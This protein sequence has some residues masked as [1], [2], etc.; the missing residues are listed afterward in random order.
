MAAGYQILDEP[1]PG[2]LAQVAVNPM[3]PLLAS[4]LAGSWLALPWFALNSFAMGSPTRKREI[5][6]VL[7]GGAGSILI[8]IGLIWVA[9]ATNMTRGGLG[10]AILVP[11]LWKLGVAYALFV[12][13]RRS[14]ALYEYYGGKVRNP[15][16]LL[17][18]AAVARENVLD[19][20]GSFWVV[21]WS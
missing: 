14:F 12:A 9:A 1:N 20:L 18:V 4:M 3:W 8:A 5:G 2:A 11:T 21:V 15:L 7:C 19:A 13:Q 17:V 6:L 16:L 10:Y